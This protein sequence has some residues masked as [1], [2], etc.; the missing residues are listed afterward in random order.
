[1]T[2]ATPS[3]KLEIAHE[4]IAAL[5]SDLRKA[6]LAKRV[7]RELLEQASTRDM[8]QEWLDQRREALLLTRDE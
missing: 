2:V 6:E 3:W 5:R 4:I 8:P 1:V 7:L